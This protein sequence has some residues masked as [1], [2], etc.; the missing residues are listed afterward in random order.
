MA[1]LAPTETTLI[2]DALGCA[3]N[4]HIDL[5]D[6]VGQQAV[7]RF[8]IRLL[9]LFFGAAW[10]VLDTVVEVAIASDIRANGRSPWQPAEKEKLLNAGIG[11]D[12]PPVPSDIWRACVQLY[13]NSIE[14]RHSLVHRTA[15]V[16]P[17]GDLV[18][19]TKAKTSL[20]PVT[21][22]QQAAFCELAQFVALCF[23]TGSMT[24]RQ[25]HRCLG[26]LGVL[27]SLHGLSDLPLGR[28]GEVIRLKYRLADDG[29]LPIA[30]IKSHVAGAAPG[31]GGIDLELSRP[32]LVGVLRGE[33]D[34]VAGESLFIDIASPP[35]WLE[36]G[37]PSD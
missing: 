15:Q 1:V 34:D 24:N 37:L 31:Y 2:M 5:I 4:F 35:P 13:I 29:L 8:R 10:K 17:N 6:N 26:R 33:L 21:L 30:K 12:M 36:R 22:R 11:A 14:V 19:E 7:D 25:R 20:P 16:K 27:Q 18:G 3:K 32:D 28:E 23:E 9:S